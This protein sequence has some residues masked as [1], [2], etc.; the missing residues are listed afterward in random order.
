[1]EE[2]LDE[3]REKLNLYPKSAQRYSK[4]CREIQGFLKLINTI[5][6]SE[7]PLKFNLFYS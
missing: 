5:K 3:V 1:M 7:F 4:K 6:F 2:K